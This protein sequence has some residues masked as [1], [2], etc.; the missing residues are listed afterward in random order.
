VRSRLSP[1]YRARHRRV[2]TLRRARLLTKATSSTCSCSHIGAVG[3][4]RSGGVKPGVAILQGK[5]LLL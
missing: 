3:T 1:A 2:V 4:C 5:A